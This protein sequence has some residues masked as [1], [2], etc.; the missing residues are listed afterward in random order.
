VVGVWFLSVCVIQQERPVL[1][2][3]FILW[4]LIFVVFVVFVVFDLS[5]V[6]YVVHRHDDKVRRLE[7][8]AVFCATWSV[9]RKDVC[10]E[11]TNVWRYIAYLKHE[12][13]IQDEAIIDRF[14]SSGRPNNDAIKGDEIG[15]GMLDEQRTGRKKGTSKVQQ[16]WFGV[17]TEEVRLG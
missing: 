8:I 11:L 6:V 5:F 17:A 13:T 7:L 4:F 1:T 15:T 2:C 14:I 16:S 9:K 3:L 10:M 12:I